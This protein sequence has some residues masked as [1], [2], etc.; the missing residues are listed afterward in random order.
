MSPK[1]DTIAFMDD[2]TT[3]R[4]LGF[5]DEFWIAFV[6]MVGFF[7]KI[8]FDISTGYTFQARNLGM[9]TYLEPGQAHEGTLGVIQYLFENH[10]L[11]DFDPRTVSGFESPPLFHILCAFFLDLF[12]RAAGWKIGTCLHTLQCFNA[13]FVTA[14]S[15]SEIG[16]LR[17]C[18]LVG[19]E[20]GN[21]V[22]QGR[23][24]GI[25]RRA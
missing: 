15:L 3:K 6:I 18:G 8:I 19:R 2:N 9:W 11:P 24:Q 23:L 5:P 16:I 4:I 12:H 14:G 21:R 22:S 7:L 13:I 25:Q 17:K 1:H 20:L 10:R